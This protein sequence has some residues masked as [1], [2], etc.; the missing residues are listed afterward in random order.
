MSTMVS[1]TRLNVTLLVHCFRLFGARIGYW[2]RGAAVDWGIASQDGRS[3]ARFPVGSFKTFSIP[4]VRSVLRNFLKRKLPPAS[5][6]DNCAVLVVRNAQVI[7]GAQH[8]IPLLRLHDVLRE[9]FT[10]TLMGWKYPNISFDINRWIQYWVHIF[11]LSS[12]MRK[13][14]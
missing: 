2:T 3:L 4:G 12:I 6:T 10:C 11:I 8:S 14:V 13:K 5:R 1:R 9:S 7:V